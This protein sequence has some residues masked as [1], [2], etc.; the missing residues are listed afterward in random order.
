MKNALFVIDA[1]NDFCLPTGTLSVPGALD[2]MKRLS[3]F[4]SKNKKHIENVTLTMDTHYVLDISHPTFWQDKNGNFPK[5]FTLITSSDVDNGVWTPRFRP[6]LAIKYIHD[7]EVNGEFPHVIWPEHCIMGSTGA[8]FVDVLM[9]SVKEWQ[10]DTLNFYSVHT[11]G[12]SPLSEHFGIFEAN[13]PI[14]NDPSTQLNQNL[15]TA[16]NKYDNIY[17]SGEAKSHCVATTLKQ[18]MKFPDLA[19]KFI[20]LE[21]CM[22]N[23]PTF[24]HLADSIYDDAKNMGIHFAKSTDIN[25]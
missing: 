3:T 8:A 5:P 9:D 25:L 24:E 19:K 23:V 11:K 12:I 20:I 13:V 6:S 4:L 10:R 21:D 16:L 2:D 18:A 15:I 7:L 17:F 22:S 14:S 1:Q